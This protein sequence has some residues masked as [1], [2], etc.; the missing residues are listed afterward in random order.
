MGWAVSEVDL[1]EEEE[2]AQALEELMREEGNEVEEEREQKDH[3]VITL[4]CFI[5][6][7]FRFI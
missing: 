7:D 6:R 3:Q 5:F 4:P 2:D 1:Q